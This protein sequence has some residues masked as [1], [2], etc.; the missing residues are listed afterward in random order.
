MYKS[1]LFLSVL[2]IFLCSCKKDVKQNSKS[3]TSNTNAQTLVHDGLT[4]EYI[5]YIPDSY[6]NSIAVPLLFNFHGNGGSASNFMAEA[7]MRTLAETENFILVFPQGSCLNGTSHWNPCPLGA[8]NKSTADDVGFVAALINTIS[9]Q[10][11]VDLDRVYASGYSN[12][13]MMA[14]GLANYKSELF[15]AVASVSGAMLEC[16]GPTNHPMPVVHLHGTSDGVIPYNGNNFFSS[17]QSTLQ[18]WIGFNNTSTNPTVNSDNTGGKTVEHYVYD[19]GK[20]SVSVEHYKYIG[21]DHTWF[22]ATYQGQ[23]TSELIWNFVSRYD[24]NGLR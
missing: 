20:N 10:Y 7:D 4:R 19:Q 21:G 5:L 16:I 1:T 6:N 8:D 23:S 22:E 3:C 24:I 14:Y 13:G 9:A 12:G 15:A 11:K 2:V 18:H 17:V